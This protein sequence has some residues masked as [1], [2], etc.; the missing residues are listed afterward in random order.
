MEDMHT[1]QRKNAIKILSAMRS[2]TVWTHLAKDCHTIEVFRTGKPVM[3][4][5]FNPRI[6]LMEIRSFPIF[7]A[8]GNVHNGAGTCP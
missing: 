7:D 2:I 8:T 4:E 1:F 5:K 6:G 3:L